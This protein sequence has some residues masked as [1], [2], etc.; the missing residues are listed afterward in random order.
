M[1][2]WRGR[3]KAALRAGKTPSREET[4]VHRRP[5]STTVV[6]SGYTA[7]FRGRKPMQAARWSQGHGPRAPGA[8]HTSLGRSFFIQRAMKNSGN[9]TQRKDVDSESFQKGNFLATWRANPQA[10]NPYR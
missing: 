4:E 10:L 6:Q 9:F 3:L 5:G 7:W 8:P 2:C 1:G